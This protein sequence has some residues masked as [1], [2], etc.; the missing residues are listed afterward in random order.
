MHPRA[1]RPLL[2]LSLAALPWLVGQVLQRLA[3]RLQRSAL[4][5]LAIERA[6]RVRASGARAP[7]RWLLL[8]LGLWLA[9]CWGLDRLFPPPL[10]GTGGAT[11]V[12]AADGTPL[13]AFPDREGTWRYP[14]APDEVSPYYLQ[15]LLGY[16]DRWFRHHGGVNPLA[17]GR[18]A[19]QRL[20]HGRVVSGGSTLSMQV[21]RILDPHPRTV[22]GKL[23]QSLRA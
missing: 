6:R 15:A 2:R 18:A 19:W 5:L 1:L 7:G 4:P 14:V 3:P 22:G 13:R 16:E 9:G 10:P 20:R 11:V 8:A 12:L 17:L 21:A 23:R